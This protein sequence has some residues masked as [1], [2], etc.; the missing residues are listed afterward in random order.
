M[1]PAPEPTSAPAAH[2]RE[3]LRARL[4]LF[5]AGVMWSLGGLFIKGLSASPVWHATAIGIAFHRSLFAA[6]CL[7]P[8]LR[9]RKLPRLPDVLGAVVIY[10]SLLVLYI[11][12]MQGTTAANAIFLQDTAPL[13]ALVLGPLFFGE[14]FRKAD[15]WS[16]FIAMSGVAILFCGSFQ[17]AERLPLLMGAASG[18][19]FGLFQL[20][21]RRMRYADPVAVTAINN[22]GVSVLACAL[23]G[24][25]LGL[26]GGR[27]AELTLLPRALSG[28]HALWPVAGLFVVMG[29]V[30]FAVPYVLFTSGLRRVP[31]VEG[32]LLALVE[33][34]LN[35]LWVALFLHERPSGATLVGG[36]MILFA[37]AARYLLFR[38]KGEGTSPS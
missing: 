14:P 37:L 26:F 5:M 23:L 12:A 1:P 35:P 17:G 38:P 19:M 3:L 8:F 30:Q 20:W 21:L 36:G 27:A 6:L 2:H 7:L 29:V 33:P 13:Y 4:S 10:I 18:V 32:G 15:V 28:D 11:A 9:G 24:S 22:V 16:L 25:G 31:A 34:V